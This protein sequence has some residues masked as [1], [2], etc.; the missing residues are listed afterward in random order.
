MIENGIQTEVLRH[1]E[2]PDS[3]RPPGEPEPTSQQQHAK[4]VRAPD[5]ATVAACDALEA[6]EHREL[7]KHGVN[8]PGSQNQEGHVCHIS[9][10]VE[11]AGFKILVVEVSGDVL[12]AIRSRDAKSSKL[13]SPTGTKTKR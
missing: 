10:Q 2:T 13:T 6:P 8:G 3:H 11:E 4:L 5:C 7:L 12:K 1:L 9:V